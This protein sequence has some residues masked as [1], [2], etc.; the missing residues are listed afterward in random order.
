MSAFKLFYYFLIAILLSSL[1]TA[2]TIHGT[3][4]DLSL[5]KLNNAMVELNT[6]PKQLVVAQNGSYSFNV[7]SG[8]YTI[9][10]QLIQKNTVI[11]SVEENITVTQDGS[12]VLDLILFPDIEEG[13][14]DV[15]IGF[16]GDIIE[17]NAKKTN[18]LI[19]VVVFL[20]LL[21]SL[22]GI[23]FYKNKKQKYTKSEDEKIDHEKKEG[24]Y[25]DDLGQVIKIIEQEGGRTTQKEIRRQIPLSEAKI[26]L[27]IAELGHKGVIEKIKKGR[28]NIIILKKK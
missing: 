22:I 28:G 15:D 25:E 17:P 6:S 12:Y 1:A 23:Y 8:A 27:M 18:V 11:A 14:E 16:N 19:F 5:N 13:L 9:K 7:P 21:L 2:T 26:S 10:A 24:R 4:Y 20:I 3:V